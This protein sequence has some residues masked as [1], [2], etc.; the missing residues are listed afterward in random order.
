MTLAASD[1]CGGP[2]GNA[3]CDPGDGVNIA[4]VAAII[5]HLFVSQD[6]LCCRAEADINRSGGDEPAEADITFGDVAVLVDHL[7]IG[8]RPL[9]ECS[10]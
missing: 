6:A 8:G 2:V 5:D 7:F 1:C 10:R 3:N 4:D 9:A